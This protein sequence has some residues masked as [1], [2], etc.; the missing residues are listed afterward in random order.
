VNS[1]IKVVALCTGNAARSVMLGFMLTD[2]VEANGLHW[3]VRS[4][5]T[6]A[7]E[8]SAMSS[9]TRDAL[10]L[11]DGL[12][13]HRYGAHRSRQ[14]TNYDVEWADALLCTEANH[15]RFVRD[16]FE[17]GTPKAVSLGQFLREAPLDLPLK[18]QLRYVSALEPLDYFDVSDPAGKDQ[19]A[20]NEC[21]TTLWDM[22]QSFATL[23]AE[24][25]L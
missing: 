23:V 21:A 24:E 25:D 20:Y 12:G 7:V 1:P 4:A 3:S 6:H 16:N 15:V 14:L 13:E 22:A 2:I 17:D 5:G 10:L 11:V 8:D 18:D 9:R 19:A